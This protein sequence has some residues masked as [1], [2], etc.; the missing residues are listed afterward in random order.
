[1]IPT[2]GATHYWIPLWAF[3]V[4]IH[5]VAFTMTDGTM[6]FTLNL[7]K[8]TRT[9]HIIIRLYIIHLITEALLLPP[10]LPHLSCGHVWYI[11]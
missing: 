1:M 3:L 6:H 10:P 4:S 9:I 5:G 7:V 2:G 11:V 8:V